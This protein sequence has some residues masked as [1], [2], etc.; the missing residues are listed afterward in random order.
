MAFSAVF[1]IEKSTGKISDRWF[2][3]TI[4]NSNKRFSY[5]EAQEVLD[6][7]SRGTFDTPLHEL[8]RI[9]K[10]YREENK[11]NGAIEFETDEVKFELDLQKSP[12]GHDEND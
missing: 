6:K 5:E 9:A 3:K 10:I 7:V 8:N 11:K 12:F 4:I 2:G 1:D